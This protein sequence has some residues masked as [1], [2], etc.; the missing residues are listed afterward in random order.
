MSFSLRTS[1]GCLARF[2]PVPLCLQ[3]RLVLGNSRTCLV[4]AGVGWGSVLSEKAPRRFMGS[5]QTLASLVLKSHRRSFSAFNS[6]SFIS[7]FHEIY[8]CSG[9]RET[10]LCG[11]GYSAKS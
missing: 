2:L 6:L 11:S 8:R 1:D 7:A 5:L 4:V 10:R 3:A 9:R